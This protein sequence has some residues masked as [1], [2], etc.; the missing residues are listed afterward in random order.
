MLTILNMLTVLN[1]D[2]FYVNYMYLYN[3]KMKQRV[4][5]QLY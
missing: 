5:T 3:L 2:V 4:V 1:M